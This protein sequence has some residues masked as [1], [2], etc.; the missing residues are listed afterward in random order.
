MA[1]KK[2]Y[3]GCETLQ[4]LLHLVV[5]G[6]KDG[7]WTGFWGYI[8]DDH[9]GIFPEVSVGSFFDGVFE[10]TLSKT[11]HDL[12]T[13]YI[14]GL[15]PT[16]YCEDEGCLPAASGPKFLYAAFILLPCAVAKYL[17][18]QKSMLWIP[19]VD[20]VP[21][22]A[23]MLAGWGL[24]DAWMQLF[25][26]I[27]ADVALGLQTNSTTSEMWCAAPLYEGGTPDCCVLDLSLAMLLTLFAAL[28]ING[29][30]QLAASMAAASYHSHHVHL[31]ESLNQLLARALAVSV[32]VV[33]NMA[34]SAY[35]LRGVRPEQTTVQFDLL[36][37]WA[38]A[39]TLAGSMIA[40][41]CELREH[42]LYHQ[43]SEAEKESERQE[44]ERVAQAAASAY[45]PPNAAGTTPSRPRE[46]AECYSEAAEV[47]AMSPA[48]NLLGTA[49]CESW[50]T[51]LP[52]SRAKVVTLKMTEIRTRIE[53]QNLFKGSLGWTSG[54][55]WTNVATAIFP[56]MVAPTGTVP[57]PWTIIANFSIA[58]LLSMMA[59]L[60]LILSGDDPTA[61]PWNE[62]LAR[63]DVEHYFMTG[64]FSFFVGWAWVIVLRGAYV[65]LGRVVDFFARGA[66]FLLD[67]SPAK[68]HR[69]AELASVVL[70]LPLLTAFFFVL[71]HRMKKAYR[72]AIGLRAKRSWSLLVGKSAKEGS[73]LHSFLGQAKMQMVVKS[74]K[75]TTSE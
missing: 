55:S 66:N 9:D 41:R 75:G 17:S 48:A 64:S 36:T 40:V 62:M 67:V 50:D 69:A 43:L 3:N 47:G 22:M 33:W 32:M 19:A 61:V 63:E 2:Q 38:V 54:C 37:F 39:I 35:V 26:E 60:W 20:T 58:L 13:A 57:N 31:L 46:S 45:V 30:H 68:M 8:V 72:D 44:A 51:E 53:V 12:L 6:Y 21:V 59:L 5:S 74:M 1:S 42:D 29:L 71:K 52:P 14:F 65:Y 15:N 25:T 24:G 56:T 28:S 49:A 10:Y 23:G 16:P 18:T 73:K 11:S 70:F 7:G 34:L 27:S 4:R